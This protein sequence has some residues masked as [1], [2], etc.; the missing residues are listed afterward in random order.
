MTTKRAMHLFESTG[1]TATK[2]GLY[3]GETKQACLDYA[4][5]QNITISA[6]LLADTDPAND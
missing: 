1:I 5:A 2:N 6:K 4:A 3:C